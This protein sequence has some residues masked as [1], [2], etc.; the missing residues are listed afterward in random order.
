MRKNWIKKTAVLALSAAVMGSTIAGCGGAK[1]Q[2]DETAVA[3]TL[4]DEEILLK[5]INFWAKYQE[6]LVNSASQTY[7]SIF[8]SNGY[9]DEQARE[10]VEQYAGSLDTVMDNVLESVETFHVIANHAEEY[11]VTLSDADLKRID[12]AADQFIK[13]NKKSITTLM[14]ADKDTVVEALKYYTIYIKMMPL[15]EAVGLDEEVSEEEALM[16]TYSYVYVELGETQ[17]ENGETVSMTD[18][19]KTQKGNELQNF[20]DE[21]RASGET[22][23]DAAAEEAGYS[24]S[25]HSYH[26]SD[27]EDALID[28]NKV[29]EELAVGS[30][31]DVIELKTDDELT[32]IA[33]LRLDTDKDLEQIET[34]KQSIIDE[35]KGECFE[36]LLESWKAEQEFTVNE[37]VT[38]TIK[39]EDNLYQMKTSQD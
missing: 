7:Y 22:D 3:A 16:K 29:A 4:G 13:D 27:E 36:A 21:F 33:I 20:I 39:L 9:T 25:A 1:S 11:G 6:A 31:S 18:A 15:M 26:P 10:A 24:V 5:E 28:L 12:E 19:E 17:D 34:K 32:G 38:G 30:V 37:K 2:I 35:R 14:S 8:V 23:F